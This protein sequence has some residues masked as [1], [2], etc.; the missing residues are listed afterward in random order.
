[1][2]VQEVLNV[3]SAT[4]FE[5]GIFIQPAFVYGLRYFFRDEL[6][7]IFHMMWPNRLIHSWRKQ[8][9]SHYTARTIKI[10]CLLVDHVV[11][12]ILVPFSRD[13]V[14]RTN[15]FFIPAPEVFF[16]FGKKPGTW[17]NCRL[18]IL[19]R[20]R[21]YWNDSFWYLDTKNV[22]INVFIFDILAGNR[23]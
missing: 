12:C 23:L 11:F 1:M 14:K 4:D 21:C 7:I 5:V 17:T 2:R 13:I 20:Y 6:S 10:K 9:R 3:L 22:Q 18:I 19:Y 15:H 16:F 8:L